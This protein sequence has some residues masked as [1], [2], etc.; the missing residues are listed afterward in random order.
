MHHLSF[1]R[2]L[3][4]KIKVV[5]IEDSVSEDKLLLAILKVRIKTF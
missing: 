4:S 2:K 5:E 3:E 1:Q